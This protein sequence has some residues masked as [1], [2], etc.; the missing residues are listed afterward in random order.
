MDEVWEHMSTLNWNL[1]YSL[2]DTQNY[3]LS[4]CSVTYYVQGTVVES[5]GAFENWVASPLV[6]YA[7]YIMI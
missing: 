7:A 5:G 6:A 2:S 1:N 3:T 4:H